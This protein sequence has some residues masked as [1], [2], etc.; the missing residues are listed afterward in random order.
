MNIKRQIPNIITSA[1]LFCGCLALTF[2]AQGELQIAA[3]L[4]LA[5]AFFDFFDGMAARLLKVTSPM[6]AEMDSLADVITFG[7]VPAYLAFEL[8]QNSNLPEWAPYLAFLIAV[9][10]AFRLAKFNVD[11][12][13]TDSFIGM[14][15]PAN[16]LFWISI[17]LMVWQTKSGFEWIDTSNIAYFFKKI[18]TIYFFVFLLSY[19]LVAEIPLLS[20][21][22]KQLGWKGNE[23]RF[24]LLM[25]SVVLI[26][27]FIFA[28]IP[29]ILLLYFIL[30]LIENSRSNHE[31][32]SRN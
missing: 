13:Q 23:N 15:T 26:A 19:A 9:F 1:N 17:P 6:G 27:L 30:S 21:K 20:L 31:I 4:V 14:P 7:V 18:P 25:A 5:G 8:L 28:A 24:I 32:Q 11:D 22:F 3:V 12:R 10:S 2:I 16:A 29:F